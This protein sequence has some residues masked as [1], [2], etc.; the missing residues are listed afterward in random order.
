MSEE[1]KQNGSGSSVH[2]GNSIGAA[3][4]KNSESISKSKSKTCK[5]S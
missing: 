1:I 3:D 2:D 5:E 4:T